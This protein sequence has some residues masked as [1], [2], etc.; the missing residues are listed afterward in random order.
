VDCILVE[1]FDPEYAIS[2]DCQPIVLR[3]DGIHYNAAGA[4]CQ[5]LLADGIAAP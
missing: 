1:D 5:V 3:P 4:V 2:T